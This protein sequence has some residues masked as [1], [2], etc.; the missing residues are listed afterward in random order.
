MIT[1]K[2]KRYTYKSVKCGMKR[3]VY[4]INEY[5][6]FRQLYAFISIGEFGRRMLIRSQHIADLSTRINAK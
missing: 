4:H 5:E 3:F 1:I 2:L 6:Q